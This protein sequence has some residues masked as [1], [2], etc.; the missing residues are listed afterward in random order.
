LF[1]RGIGPALSRRSRDLGAI[2]EAP[3]HAQIDAVG[4]PKLS[5]RSA[6][7]PPGLIFLVAGLIIIAFGSGVRVGFVSDDFQWLNRAASGQLGWSQ[8]F[9][10]HTH[11]NALP[12]AELLFNYEFKV[13]GYHASWYHLFDLAG[14]L[15]AAMLLYALALRLGFRRTEAAGAT[16]LAAVATSAA[17][18]VYWP[19][20]DFHLWASVS[21]LAALVLYIES[22]QRPNRLAFIASVAFAVASALIKSEGIAVLF[23]VLAYELFWCK[24]P[25]RSWIAV[26]GLALRAA[27]FVASAALVVAWELT[28]T[29]PLRSESR[30]GVNMISRAIDYLRMIVVPDDPSLLVSQVGGIRSH[31]LLGWLAAAGAVTLAVWFVVS[32]GTA[33]IGRAAAGFGVLWLGAIIAALPITEGA[34]SRYVY[35]ATLVTF[36]AAARGTGILLERLVTRVS[37]KRLVASAAILFAVLLL[38]EVAATERRSSD[39]RVASIESTAFRD[40]VL[41]SHPGLSPNTTIY[42]IGSPLDSGSARLVF[43]DPRLRISPESLPSIT[44]AESVDAVRHKLPSGKAWAF[45]RLPSGRYV[46]LAL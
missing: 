19:A 29:D 15:L 45:Q 35:L 6:A 43:A 5:W 38:V 11:F 21:A 40:A 37:R 26:R 9:D 30:I 28:A 18:A 10:V 32:I 24:E 17:Q 8:A 2:V 20:A 14:Q 41:A 13:F 1:I 27:P 39:L 4:P 46:E 25:V 42:L 3:N 33:I 36:L 16:A 22:R 34:Q 7:Q 44:V 31:H 23:G 12:L